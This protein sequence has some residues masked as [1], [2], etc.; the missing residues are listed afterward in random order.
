MRMGERE[1]ALGDCRERE[2]D[3][4][5]FHKKGGPPL[6]EWLFVEVA[7]ID[8][9]WLMGEKNSLGVDTLGEDV[10]SKVAN[11]LRGFVGGTETIGF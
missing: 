9:G 7:G 11:L 3:R 2:T 8:V 5:P 1:F 10:L 6:F 4:F